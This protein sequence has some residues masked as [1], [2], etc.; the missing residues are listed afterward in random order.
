MSPLRLC[1]PLTLLALLTSFVFAATPAQLEAIYDAADEARSL[2]KTRE[3]HQLLE[4][5]AT[6]GHVPSMLELG[7][8]LGQGYVYGEKY[9]KQVAPDSAAAMAW[10]TKARDSGEA[11]GLRF[12]AMLQLSGGYGHV[13][14]GNVQGLVNP[15]A[16]VR[17]LVQLAD[18]GDAES[19]YL[20]ATIYDTERYQ[21][22]DPKQA[23]HWYQKAI[24]A[25]LTEG[26][27]TRADWLRYAIETP[28]E[29]KRTAYETQLK[30]AEQH[31][32][33]SQPRSDAFSSYVRSLYDGGMP[34]NEIA[35]TVG[36]AF[37]A[38]VA[39]DFYAAIW[40]LSA[41]GIS[42]GVS[43]DLSK[44]LSAAQ[45]AELQAIRNNKRL[46]GDPQPRLRP[47][48]GWTEPDG[49]ALVQSTAQSPTGTAP[50][51]GT[52]TATGTV[53]VA[54]SGDAADLYRRGEAAMRENAFEDARKLF[55]DAADKGN[56]NA[57]YRYA[58]ML[59]NGEGGPTD[60]AAARRYFL[61]S[62]EAGDQRAMTTYGRMLINGH[63]GPADIQTG[64][65]WMEKAAQSYSAAA[66]GLAIA[67]EFGNSL[68]RDLNKAIQWYDKA[69]ELG[70]VSARQSAERLRSAASTPEQKRAAYNAQIA[71]A[72]SEQ[73]PSR[74]RGQALL[75]YL[76]ASYDS[77]LSPQA[78]AQAIRPEVQALL[79]QDFYAVHY[80][81]MAANPTL[82]PALEQLL[83][84][85]QMEISARIAAN[86]RSAPTG[87]TR[88]QGWSQAFADGKIPAGLIT[89]PRPANPQLTGAIA[90]VKSWDELFDVVAAEKHKFEAE[91]YGRNFAIFR[92]SQPEEIRRAYRAAL[93][94]NKPRTEDVRGE[95]AGRMFLAYHQALFASDLS[96]QEAADFARE[97]FV[98][99]VGADSH[100]GFQGIPTGIHVALFREFLTPAQ[101]AQITGI[102]NEM[103]AAMRSGSGS[104]PIGQQ[105][106]ATGFTTIQEYPNN[107]R[108]NLPGHWLLVATF[109]GN[110]NRI[111]TQVRFDGADG[112]VTRMVTDALTSSAATYPAA[113]IETQATYTAGSWFKVIVNFQDLR[114]EANHRNDGSMRGEVY[115]SNNR[116]IGNVHFYK[117]L[118][119]DYVNLARQAGAANNPEAAIHYYSEA[120]KHRRMAS[121]FISRSTIHY[122]SSK[123]Y[124]AAI[125]DLSEALK[126][127]PKNGT[128]LYNRMLS[129]YYNEQYAEAL[130]DADRMIAD[131]PSHSKIPDAHFKRGDI[132]WWLKR[133]D[134]ADKAYALAIRLK[135]ELAQT[136]R[137]ESTRSG[138]FATILERSEE[139]N[140]IWQQ[141]DAGIAQSTATL[142]AAN[143][144][145]LTAHSGQRTSDAQAS[146]GPIQQINRLYTA[147]QAN[148]A[149]REN[150]KSVLPT[151]DQ[152]AA[153]EQIARLIAPAKQESERNNSEQNRKLRENQPG[154]AEFLAG[155]RAFNDGNPAEA[156]RLWEKAE[157]LGQP[158][159]MVNL[160]SM[161]YGKG[162][163]G[164]AA[165]D[166]QRAR[167]LIQKAAQSGIPTALTSLSAIYAGQYEGRP[168]HTKGLELAIKG[169]EGGYAYAGYLRYYH[170]LRLRIEES[171]NFVLLMPGSPKYKAAE[172]QVQAALSSL[173]HAALLGEDA[174]MYALARYHFYGQL[175]GLRHGF[176]IDKQGLNLPLAR[177]WFEQAMT[178]DKNQNSRAHEAAKNTIATIDATLALSK[179]REWNAEDILSALEADI[180]Q[181]TIAYMINREGA[182]LPQRAYARMV[183]A[184]AWKKVPE[185]SALGTELIFHMVTG[186]DDAA[187]SLAAAAIAERKTS[188]KANT[189]PEDSPAL[190]KR[191]AAGDPAAA[192]A[193]YQILSARHPRGWPEG[194]PPI[195]EVR[196]RA[197]AKN[198]A[199]ARYL[200]VI[201]EG[202]QYNSDKS[203]LDHARMVRL[204]RESA[205]AADAEAARKLGDLYSAVGSSQGLRPNLA[206]AEYWYI[207]AAALAWPEQFTHG[208]SAPP[209]TLLSQ[210][211]SLNIPVASFSGGMSLP[212]RNEA[213]Q[214]WV[215]ELRKRGGAFKELADEQVAYYRTN[216]SGNY[217]IEPQ[218]DALPP[219]LPRLSERE[220]SRL[221]N[222][223]GR[224]N[225][226]A[227]LTLARAYAYGEGG[228][229]QRDDR[230]VELYLKAA[231]QGSKE[232][233]AALADHYENGY[234]VNKD[235]LKAMEFRARAEGRTPS[236]T[237]L[238]LAAGEAAQ[239]DS[240]TRHLAEGYYRK[241]AQTGSALAMSRLAGL[242]AKENPEESLQLLQQAAQAGE[243]S[244]MVSL[245]FKYEKGED[246]LPQDI[247][248]SFYWREKAAEAG[249]RMMMSSTA[250]AYQRGTR[251]APKDLRKA[252]YWHRKAFEA[253][254]SSASSAI[255]LIERELGIPA[256]SQP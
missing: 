93:S 245:C 59:F 96:P 204:T 240:D 144:A 97:D 211:Y 26:T 41:T 13:N 159:A 249:D 176:V 129:Y 162:I 201:T 137:A 238:A 242:L 2:G 183:T 248:K 23:L 35:A 233:M 164:V 60:Y 77:G 1:L 66:S 74:A 209:E 198:Y 69:A 140:R 196:M 79:E 130:A 132:L 78:A 107:F 75:E 118:D 120:L 149:R 54:G 71:A 99:M 165:Q 110:G 182:R 232:A 251:G 8:I 133:G 87:I 16:G 199:P 150:R 15:E 104:V 86:Q 169:Y 30:A 90:D 72:A 128:A 63:G 14:Y 175:P 231:Q 40:V 142:A 243:P 203:K 255:L 158:Q 193:L 184:E 223:A 135:P 239:K 55:K 7:A 58:L 185:Y 10:F 170:T 29:Q 17:T 213:T 44:R 112:N 27:N 123:D 230:A 214:R 131:A 241:A 192:Y 224:G 151:A 160:A 222:Q 155:N 236:A 91:N 9:D 210:I 94:R 152:T 42:Q 49:A 252:L 191:Y 153:L 24:D 235:L 106:A 228:V 64:L 157:A 180:P 101:S 116:H 247:A 33:P 85:A 56:R 3:A 197:T 138:I 19:M 225:L 189:T 100:A 246:G 80:A 83:S 126:L 187:R 113:V 125:S 38:L 147:L 109:I 145:A 171:N 21:R 122:N 215:R 36:D 114:F 22:H 62:A 216:E 146:A 47:G 190:R 68:P 250:Y 61:L 73:N 34:Q 173:S 234:G 143:Q 178:H 51:T 82:R 43:A 46:P 154:S 50:A 117:R 124:P 226:T 127:E 52:T 48:Q 102:A 148:F 12:Y 174:A 181:H 53:S 92:P 45:T 156:V 136:T 20:L 139:S 84:P 18:K 4:Q 81:R 212:P 88:G 220:L 67:Y 57:R 65:G 195:T 31:R 177:F 11:D 108:R 76:R 168:D 167:E 206:E 105:S 205:E 244:A 217:N 202:L 5:A 115:D 218:I 6:K 221:E 119:L 179:G 208:F 254:E 95:F 200:S 172:E 227:L 207:Q 111:E 141:L 237:D 28:L 229:R 89:P 37:D 134:E 103:L 70:S 188:V 98:N 166:F 121:Y 163:P 256:G 32:R 25:G 186:P 39:T 194:E 161:V 253:G 219:E